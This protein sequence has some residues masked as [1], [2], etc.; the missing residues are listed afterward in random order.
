MAKSS[1]KYPQ[2]GSV[3]SLSKGAPKAKVKAVEIP[4]DAPVAR[5]SGGAVVIN[6]NPTNRGRTKQG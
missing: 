1:S 5:M 2:G 6:S 4:A 3:D